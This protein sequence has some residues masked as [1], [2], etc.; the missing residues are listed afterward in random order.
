MSYYEE[1]SLASVLSLLPEEE[2]A[3]W[4]EMEEELP[5]LEEYLAEA[6]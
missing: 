5:E 4:E 1:L 3:E 6:A 2:M